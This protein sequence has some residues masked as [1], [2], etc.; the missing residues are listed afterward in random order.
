MVPISLIF[1]QRW[2][3]DLNQILGG[4][5]LLIAELADRAGQRRRQEVPDSKSCMGFRWERK[6]MILN[7]L[8]RRNDRRL[9]CGLR[10]IPIYC[11][12]SKPERLIKSDRGRKSRPNL[13]LFGPLKWGEGWAKYLSQFHQFIL[14]PNL[15]YIY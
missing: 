10:K 13:T 6:S 11:S 2:V 15:W 8:E 7:D 14:W 5:Y 3:I 9:L 1:S 4:W 12:V